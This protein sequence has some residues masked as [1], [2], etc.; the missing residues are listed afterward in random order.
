MIENRWKT[1]HNSSKR[2]DVF[3][4]KTCF[5]GV[6][7]NVCQKSIRKIWLIL[8]RNAGQEYKIRDKKI[9]LID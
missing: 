1:F 5:F 3:L 4:G 7:Y 6:N 8:I 2:L 9:V